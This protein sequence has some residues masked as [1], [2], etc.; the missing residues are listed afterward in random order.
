MVSKIGLLNHFM[1]VNYVSLCMSRIYLNQ[2]FKKKLK[3]DKQTKNITEPRNMT[4]RNVHPYILSYSSNISCIF[5]ISNWKINSY[6]KIRKF[7]LT[8]YHFNWKNNSMNIL[9]IRNNM[10]WKKINI[11]KKKFNLETNFYIT[12]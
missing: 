8:R 5:L 3:P 7:I 10:N 9:Y 12:C 6:Q 4:Y 11:L 1:F 2:I